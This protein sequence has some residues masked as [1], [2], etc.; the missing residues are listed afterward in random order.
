MSRVICASARRRACVEGLE[1]RRLLAADLGYALQLHSDGSDEA[2]AVAVDRFGNQY[3][4]GTFTGTLDANPS[5]RRQHLLPAVGLRDVFVAKYSP[6]GALLWA[7]TAGGVGDDRAMSIA[8]DRSGDAYV[9][10]AFK[11][12]ADF[13]PGRRTFALTSAGGDDAFL[14]KLGA[15]D[16]R[17]L[18]AVRG[19][20]AG[21]EAVHALTVTPDNDV[22]ATGVLGSASGATFG[23]TTLGSAGSDDIL[24]LKTDA[25]LNVLLATRLGGS[26]AD[27]G[28]GIA[29]DANGNFHVVGQ[30]AG[31]VDFHPAASKV[32]NRTAAGA[33]DAFAITLDPAGSLG[34]ATQFGGAGDAAT[35]SAVAV[36][37]FGQLH[38]TGTFTGS[39][40]FNVD[41]GTTTNLTST[42]NSDAFVAKLTPEG[43]LVWAR[44]AGTPSTGEG[45]GRGIAVDRPG[46]VYV[47]GDTVGATA[48]GTG[49]PTGDLSSPTAFVWKLNSL[50]ASVLA[51]TF[52]SPAVVSP[53]PVYGYG[54]ALNAAG[55]IFLAGSFEGNV[56]IDPGPASRV[57]QS[58]PS[59]FLP[60]GFVVQ[61]VP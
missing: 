61:L 60:D 25:I 52:D 7:V 14:W 45:G 10:G 31:T 28:N 50:G 47:G 1:C 44:Q 4:A 29:T 40:D 27:A 57:W 58:G 24:L 37:R 55:A 12:T 53:G 48:F 56:D 16:G 42:G 51:R 39:P 43:G 34:M 20:G 19:G 8:V 36:D 3:V 21:H 9:G 26:G 23:R 54:V 30:F 6:D 11:G 49:T 15:A 18:N 17:L 32:R 35:A 13:R 33:T 38:V 22:L 5:P 59:E 2:T 46:N 41:P